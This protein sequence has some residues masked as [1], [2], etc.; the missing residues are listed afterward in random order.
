MGRTLKYLLAYLLTLLRAVA[1]RNS[2]DGWAFVNRP[3]FVARVVGG[4]PLVILS[5]GTLAPGF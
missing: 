1:V 3:L 5:A 4:R 2:I